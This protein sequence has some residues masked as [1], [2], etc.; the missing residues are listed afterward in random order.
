MVQVARNITMD[1]W[2]FLAPGQYLI[3]DRDGKFCPV[4]QQII[5]DAGI[6]RVSCRRGRR[7]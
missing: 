2:G 3:H 4:F 5:D 1:D 7:I 6:K